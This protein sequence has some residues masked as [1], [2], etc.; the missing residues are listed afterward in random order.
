VDRP[1]NQQTTN[2]QLT[3]KELKYSRH[4]VQRHQL[5]TINVLEVWQNSA[6]FGGRPIGGTVEVLL[7]KFVNW[8]SSVLPIIVFF[9][10]ADVSI[11]TQ[12]NS[13][14]S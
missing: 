9:V 6:P 12:P 10:A 7:T 3:A 13:A 4:R 1:T 2:Q 5:R 11:I 8:Q 14:E